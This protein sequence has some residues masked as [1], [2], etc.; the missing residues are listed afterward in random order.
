MHLSQWTYVMMTF[1][2]NKTGWRT[3]IANEIISMHKRIWDIM[4]ER[5]LSHCNLGLFCVSG[6][7]IYDLCSWSHS[8]PPA[9]QNCTVYFTGLYSSQDYP[10]LVKYICVGK[11]GGN[12]VARWAP[13]CIIKEGPGPLKSPNFEPWIV[14]NL[15]TPYS[16]VRWL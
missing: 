7:I 2:G 3:K 16:P 8:S 5:N 4:K 13:Y 6:D 11:S 1:G 9:G 10:G 14:R 12:L 15:I